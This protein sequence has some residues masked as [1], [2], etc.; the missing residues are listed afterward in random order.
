M[1]FPFY[2]GSDPRKSIRVYSNTYHN[3][4]EK[5]SHAAT[6]NFVAP[7]REE[8][9]WGVKLGAGF[10]G[11]GTCTGVSGFSLPNRNT[12]LYITKVGNW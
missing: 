6:I 11:T 12:F 9:E 8:T 1:D 5:S 2:S 10:S 3:I 4:R 7:I